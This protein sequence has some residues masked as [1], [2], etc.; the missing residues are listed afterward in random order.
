[1]FVD[2]R[3]SEAVVVQV[4][5]LHEVFPR[6]WEEGHCGVCKGMGRRQ[7]RGMRCAHRGGAG[8]AGQDAARGVYV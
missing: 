7:S 2:E 3:R 4:K 8:G 5:A 6:V 1:M